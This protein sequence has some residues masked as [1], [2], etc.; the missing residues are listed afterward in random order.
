MDSCTDMLLN[1]KIIICAGGDGG[2][3]WNRHLGISKHM[4]TAYGEA[5]VHRIQRQLLES[6]FN[7]IY[8]ACSYEYKDTYLLKHIKYIESPKLSGDLGDYSCVWHYK[9]FLDVYSTT[10]ILFADVYY[11]D[12]F[13]NVL[14]H[15]S[16]NHFKIYGRSDA[17]HITKNWRQGEPFAIILSSN[18][19]KKYFKSLKEVMLVLPD[20]IQKGKA[21]REDIGKYTYR[22]FVGIPYEA[23]GNVTEDT[24][25]HEWNDLTDDFDDPNDWKIKSELFP[26]IFYIK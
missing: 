23:P 11:T 7:N 24:H 25:W 5:L 26:N 13:I 12:E 10:V 6:G 3:K 17:S 22:K 20:F 2:P 8:V 21:I 16:G 18:A 1:K 19:V 9:K 4:I 15:D 14:K